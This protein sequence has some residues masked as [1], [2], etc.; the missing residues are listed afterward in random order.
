MC[1][2]I[3]CYLTSI[4][5][6]HTGSSPHTDWGFLTVILQDSRVGG[7]QFL[8]ENDSDDNS[9]G[10]SE[11]S[12][13]SKSPLWVDVPASGSTTAIPLVVNGGDYLS[14]L[15][16][17]RYKSPIHRVLIQHTTKGQPSSEPSGHEPSNLGE[18]ASSSDDD[19]HTHSVEVDNTW[20]AKE[21]AKDIKTSISSVDSTIAWERF[22]FVLF[23][24]PH[25]DTTFST[26]ENN[27]VSGSDVKRKRALLNGNYNTLAAAPAANHVDDAQQPSFGEYISSKW[28]GVQA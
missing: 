23:F 7:L 21:V 8:Y 13:G 9:D 14:L 20:T 11:H 17:G 24:Y 16:K 2:C 26:G 6:Y 4:I 5:S 27:S 12:G 19:T 3:A 15:S 10:N 18:E 1:V 22:S 25:F 28:K